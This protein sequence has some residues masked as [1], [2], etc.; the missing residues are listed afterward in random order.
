MESGT[1]PK[2]NILRYVFGVDR[3]FWLRPLNSRQ[4]FFVSAQYFGQWITDHDDRQRQPIPEPPDPTNLADI[5]E[6]EQTV[7]LILNT[8]YRN[9][10][11]VPQMVTAYD[12]RGV[13]LV[14]PSVNF[15]Y[16]PLRFQIQYNMISGQFTNFGFFRDR[17]QLSFTLTLLF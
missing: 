15:I 16:E 14:G 2:K 4:M 12:P 8:T 5:K 17:D 6:Y 3:K 13:W 1:I 10:T 11:I 7:T 9:G